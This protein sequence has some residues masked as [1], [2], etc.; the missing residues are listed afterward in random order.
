MCVFFAYFI[1]KKKQTKNS[2][3][4]LK[5]ICQS[6]VKQTHEIDECL[7]YLGNSYT[8]CHIEFTNKKN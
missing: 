6:C 5:I 7:V 4:V 2:G 8:Y 1:Y 3:L